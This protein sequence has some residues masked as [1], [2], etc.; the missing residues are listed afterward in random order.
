MRTHKTNTFAFLLLT[1]AV[2]PVRR[3]SGWGRV[4]QVRRLLGLMAFFYVTL[5]FTIYLVVDQGL[6]WTF[7]QRAGWPSR[8]VRVSRFAWG[9]RMPRS[10]SRARLSR[11]WVSLVSFRRPS[12]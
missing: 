9:E 7:I 4:V 8:K 2:S 5:H 12:T 6:A 10:C 3:L 1:L 11:N